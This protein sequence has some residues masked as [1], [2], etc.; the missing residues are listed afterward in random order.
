MREIIKILKYVIMYINK[1]EKEKSEGNAKFDNKLQLLT[2][3][4]R[5]WIFFKS[6]FFSYL[7]IRLVAV[8]MF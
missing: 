4:G 8:L 3:K 6:Q 7:T 1:I 5:H 2:L